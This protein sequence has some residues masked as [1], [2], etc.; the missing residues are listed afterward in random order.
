MSKY[1]TWGKVDLRNACKAA[2]ISYTNMTNATMRQAL[3]AHY[4]TATQVEAPAE[5]EAVVTAPAAP[6]VLEQRTDDAPAA[7]EP[8]ADPVPAEDA[9]PA[10]AEKP[11]EPVK[12]PKKPA[13][14]KDSRNG[15][16]RPA[17]GNKCAQVWAAL[18]A[19]K[20]QGTEITFATLRPT[21]NA[22][23]A[24]ATVRTQWS[25]WRKYHA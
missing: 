7:P 18:D 15:V 10:A 4:A 17:A 24:D 8:A 22:E 21:I 5:P 14:P 6:E 25:R 3:V 9:A 16:S 2:G 19:L 11:A 23:I 20:A 1:D 13:A 12:E